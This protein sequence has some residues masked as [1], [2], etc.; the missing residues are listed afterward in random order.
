MIVNANLK[1][2]DQVYK[3]LEELSTKRAATD[4]LPKLEPV[5]AL[6]KVQGDK[7]LL[8]DAYEI[9]RDLK[10][11]V[12]DENQAHV[13]SCEQQSLS[14]V[15]F[16]AN[17]LDPPRCSWSTEV[18]TAVAYEKD[19]K[20]GELTKYLANHPLYLN[21]FLQTW[22]QQFLQVHGGKQGFDLPLIPDWPTWLKVWCHHREQCFT[23]ATYQPWGWQIELPDHDSESTNP[24]NCAS[25][26]DN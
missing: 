1:P 24:A 17:L 21:P 23:G 19:K 25:Y 22:L 6:P 12:P 10:Y 20:S 11:T 8:R 15:F 5:S 18:Q 3:Y 14:R 13:A 16:A 4:Q 9:W 26:S 7:C 2:R